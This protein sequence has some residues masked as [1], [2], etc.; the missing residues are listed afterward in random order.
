MAART[1]HV[2]RSG[3][4]WIVRREGGAAQSFATQAEAVAAATRSLRNEAGQVVV[5]GR[6]GQV[7]QQNTYG[8][9][10]IQDPPK[11]TSMARKIRSVVGRLALK[12]V[13]PESDG[14]R[15]PEK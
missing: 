8:I 7:R 1:V 3:R 11:K 2:F 9:T 5:H 14:E 15:P 4:E 10:R 6:E 13:Q 12:R